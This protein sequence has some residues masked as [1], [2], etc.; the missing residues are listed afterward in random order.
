[1]LAEY[2]LVLNIHV[3]LKQNTTALHRNMTAHIIPRPLKNHGMPKK[4][5]IIWKMNQFKLILTKFNNDWN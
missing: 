1:M 3:D 4:P 5:S 2:H